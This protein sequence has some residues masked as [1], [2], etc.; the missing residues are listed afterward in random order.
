[1]AKITHSQNKTTDLLYFHCTVKETKLCIL[2]L[3]VS[4]KSDFL[5]DNQTKLITLENQIETQLKKPRNQ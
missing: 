1:M 4:S 5:L 3:Y 2:Y